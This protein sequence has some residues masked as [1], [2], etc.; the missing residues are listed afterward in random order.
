MENGRISESGSYKQLME[1]GK[2]FAE[3]IRKYKSEEHVSDDEE[4]LFEEGN[5]FV[6]VRNVNELKRLEN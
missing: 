5:I 3:F 1:N 2:A 6:V 4:D